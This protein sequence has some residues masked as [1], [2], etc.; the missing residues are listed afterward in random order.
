MNTELLRDTSSRFPL[1]DLYGFDS[2]SDE[3]IS[4][5]QKN[6]PPAQ[7]HRLEVSTWAESQT[8][9]IV[10]FL[11]ALVALLVFLPILGLVAIAVRMS[12]PGPIIFKQERM[13][14]NG[15]TFVLF[16]FRSM[17]QEQQS[18]GLITVNGDSRITGV[19]SFLRKCKLDEL[20]QFWNVLRGD[21]SLVG[22]RP[23]LPRHEALLMPFRPGITGPASLAFRFEE[24]LLSPIPPEH[25]DEYYERF[26]KPAKATIDSEYM[27][28][29]TLMTDLGILWQTAMSC[30][31]KHDSASSAAFPVFKDPMDL[32][33]TFPAE[34]YTNPELNTS[35]V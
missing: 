24:E 15:R 14:R 17:R 23:K 26:V 11:A 18:K 28:T 8:R 33:L 27:K 35:L 25:L 5:L 19:G 12:S 30:F 22:P 6:H 13:G 1:G 9:R 10:D 20:P 4:R 2:I 29:A 31:R 16:K 7:N 32:A 34:R 3:S 21:M